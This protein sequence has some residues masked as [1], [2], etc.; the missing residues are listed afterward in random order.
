MRVVLV[1]GFTQT[2][3]SWSGVAE[4]VREVAEVR[5]VNVPLK[6]SF[7]AT[8]SA[9]GDANGRGL[10]VGYSMGGRLC[11]Q[12]ALD[13]PELVEALVLV[14][15]SPGLANARDREARVA[16]D[17]KLAQSIERDGV[18]AFLE[19]WLAQPLFASVPP[20]APGLDDRHSLPAAYLAGCL[21][22]LGTGAMPSLWNRL[23]ELRV[24]VALVTGTKDQKFEQIA[25]SMYERMRGDIVHT[26]LDGGHALPLEHPA[27]LGGY[28]VAFA[29][30]HGLT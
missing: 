9:I 29:A 7:A 6:E 23:G 21:R 18:D 27:V 14:S 20:D 12:L 19:E 8:A 5:A 16:A 11:L 26:R 4:V 3:S 22:V 2:A 1:P 24:P 30:R 17:E 13:R 10:Y 25:G 15:A 28:I